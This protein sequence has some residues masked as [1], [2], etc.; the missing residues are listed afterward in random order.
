DL[1]KQHSACP[2]KREGG[3]LGQISRGQTTSE[4]ERQLFVLPQGLASR[5][6]ETRYGYHV[7]EVQ[8]KQEGRIL[9]YEQVAKKIAGYLNESVRRKAVSQYIRVLI[10]E[11]RIQGIDM[12]GA[13]SMLMQ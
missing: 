12:Q 5:P 8:R 10:G 7:V 2:S 3:D 6:V 4:F 13:D 11:A 9:E 1:A